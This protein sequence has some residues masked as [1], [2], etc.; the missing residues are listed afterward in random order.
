MSIPKK[1]SV[2]DYQERT[3]V[4]AALYARAERVMPSGYTRHM[5]V[6]K[7]H[8]QYAVSGEGCWIE[9][10]DGNRKI[11]WINNFTALIHGHNFRPVVDIVSQQ[12][13][14][15][16]S[17]ILPTEWEVKLAELLTE[18][19]PSVEQVR[20]TNSGTE[21]VMMAIKAGRA[22]TGRSGIAKMEGGYHG[23]LDLTETSFQPGPANWGPADAPHSVP[24]AV[25]TPQSILDEVLVLPLND[26]DAARALLHANAHR[27]GT[28]IIDPWRLQ[29]GLVSPTREFLHMLREE[30][31][32]LGMVLVFDEVLS[33]RSSFHG[34]QGKL[35]ITPDL[36]TM[37]KIIGGGL[38]IGAVGGRRAVMSVFALDDGEPKVKHSG[39]FTANPM[40]MAAGFVSM[41]HLTRES[42][43]HLERLSDRLRDG[44]RGLIHDMRLPAQVVGDG[45]MTGL[46]MTKMSLGNYRELA[47][48]VGSGLGVW[49]GQF[50]RAL[51]VEGI[52]SMRGGFVAS[53][54]MTMDDIEF[55]LQAVKRALQSMNH[56][57]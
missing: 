20:F 48:A 23:Q 14:D 40:S 12:S 18:R 30:T 39:T 26:I 6:T 1:T 42:F 32:A 10:A 57:E 2:P 46:L 28:V 16:M 51:S 55:T 13:A 52:S 31:R 38:P 53:T 33:L 11:D 8:P 49:I 24:H 15:L 36:T 45:S 3:S 5:A 37:G 25:G 54:P 27:V 17:C 47:Q 4:S 29:L 9:D 41:T 44:L 34:T 43:D 21:A 19:I 50:Q 7:P 22:F 56:R 35:G